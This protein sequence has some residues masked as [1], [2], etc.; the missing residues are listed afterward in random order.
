MYLSLF[1]IKLICINKFEQNLHLYFPF[2]LIIFAILLG[3][4]FSLKT[5]VKPQG[6]SGSLYAFVPTSI[7]KKK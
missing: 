6:Q 7:K 4:K 2:I 3:N 5:V 1:K